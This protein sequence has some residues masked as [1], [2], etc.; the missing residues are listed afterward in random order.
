MLLVVKERFSWINVE[1]AKMKRGWNTNYSKLRKHGVE[2]LSIKLDYEYNE[3]KLIRNLENLRQRYYRLDSLTQDLISFYALSILLCIS[4]FF[5]SPLRYLITTMRILEKSREAG[6]CPTLWTYFLLLGKSP[7]LCVLQLMF[8]SLL[9]SRTSK[10]ARKAASILHSFEHTSEEVMEYIKFFSYQIYY[11]DVE[12][13][14][15]GIFSLNESLLL[16]VGSEM[17]SFFILFI[18]AEDTVAE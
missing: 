17:L 10:E 18:Q 9:S 1:L 2:S 13:T 14:L 6:I 12:I 5:V 15:F 4:Q 8:L 16:K 3:K 7:V 11:M